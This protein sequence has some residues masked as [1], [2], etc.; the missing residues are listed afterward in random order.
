MFSPI[1]LGGGV[2]ARHA[3]MDTMGKEEY[4]G[5]GV[6]ELTPIVALDCLD[7]GVKLGRHKGKEVSERRKSI[8]FK[9]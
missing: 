9:F 4:A 8:R 6:V 5:G 1:I 2:G 3:E 7:G